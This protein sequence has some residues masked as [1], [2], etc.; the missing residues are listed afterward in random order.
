MSALY[1]CCC[2]VKFIGEGEA[3]LKKKSRRVLLAGTGNGV[4]LLSN[5]KVI[6]HANVIILKC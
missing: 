3:D 1:I 6:A 5:R 2:S 4:N